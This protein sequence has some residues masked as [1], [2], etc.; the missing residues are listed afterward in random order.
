LARAPGLLRARSRHAGLDGEPAAADEPQSPAAALTYSAALT[1]ALSAN[2]RIIA[3]RL[4][5]PINIASRDVAAERLNPEVRFE[6]SKETPKESYL[7]AFRSN[8]AANE[9]A[10]SPSRTPR[11]RPARRN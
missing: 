7:L 10:A 8:W 3:A 4:R 5:R 1:R 6:A 9:P 2:P 11:S